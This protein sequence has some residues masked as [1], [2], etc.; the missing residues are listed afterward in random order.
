MGQCTSRHLFP[1]G[2]LELG[3]THVQS[4]H[5]S[6]PESRQYLHC[7]SIFA[8]AL[9]VGVKP[10]SAVHQYF[11][12]RVLLVSNLS[13]SPLA[14]VFPSFVHA[15]FGL[16]L[17]VASQTSATVAPSTTVLLNGL[18]INVG[19]TAKKKQMLFLQVYT[20]LVSRALKRNKRSLDILPSPLP[21]KHMTL[22]GIIIFPTV[23][24]NFKRLFIYSKQPSR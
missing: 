15:I 14:T 20:V 4:E 13:V 10:F 1:Y 22:K 5:V 21:K 6:I 2:V 8:L 16:G 12:E 3:P 11:P 18:V 24:R 7:T 17:P 9:T 23:Q 19:E